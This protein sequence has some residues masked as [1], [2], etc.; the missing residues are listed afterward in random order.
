[1]TVADRA[2]GISHEDLPHIFDPFFTTR[3]NGSGLGLAISKNVVE[4]LGGSLRVESRIGEGT[5][6][7]LHLPDRA[8]PEFTH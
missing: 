3:R 6:V 4:G 8:V 2:S 5:T 1:M 7:T